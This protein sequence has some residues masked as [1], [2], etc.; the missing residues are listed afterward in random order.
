MRCSSHLLNKLQRVFK[1]SDSSEKGAQM[2]TSPC[3]S[4]HT[5]YRPLV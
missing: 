2:G 4:M 5:L 3:L 1:I